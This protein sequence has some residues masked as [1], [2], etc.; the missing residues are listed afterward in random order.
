MVN[1]TVRNKSDLTFRLKKTNHDPRLAY[2]RYD[3]PITP[4]TIEPKS[5]KTF[6]IRLLEGIQGGDVN[7]IV[8]NFLVEPNTGMMYTLKIDN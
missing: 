7:F 3:T 4:F 5:T 6:T 8:E 2:F 1:V